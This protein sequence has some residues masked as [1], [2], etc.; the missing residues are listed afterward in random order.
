MFSLLVP[1]E[2]VFSKGDTDLGNFTAV[3]HHIDT[4]NA[5]PIK[6]RMRRTPLGYA[7]EERGHLEKL[8]EAGVIEPSCSEWASPSV[9]VRKRD[10]SVRWCIDLRKLNDVTVK[11]RYPLPLLQDCI[12]ALEGCQYF[13]TLD[14]ASG[15]YQL[16]VAQ[17][18]QDKTAFVTKYGLFSFRRMPFGLCNAPATFSRA[19]SLVLR[20]LSWRSVI[21]FLDDVVVL[22]QDFKSHLA[23]LSDVLGRFDK[24]GMKLKPKKCQLLQSSV[25]FLG[26]LVSRE[27]VQIPPG[28][29]ERVGNWGVPVC[30]KDVQSFIGVVN[31]HRDHIPLF[32]KIAKPLYDIMGSSVTFRWGTEQQEAFDDLKKKMTEAPVLAYPNSDDP[33]ILDTDASDHS[34]GAELLQVQDGIE[35]LIG[36]GSFVLDPAQR[37][38]CTTR[39]ELLA[40]VR[41]TRHFR[42]YLLGRRF[43]VRTDHSSLTWLMGFKNIEGQLA[44]WIEE[45]AVYNMDIIHRPGKDHVNADGFSRIP[46]PLRACR[47]YSAGCSVEDLPCGGCKYCVRANQQW[48]RFHEDVD[49]VVPLAVRCV[50]AVSD[51]GE[52]EGSLGGDLYPGGPGDAPDDY[53]GTSDDE[54][55]EVLWSTGKLRRLD[56]PEGISESTEEDYGW[57]DQ[58][59]PEDIRKMQMDDEAT[60]VLIGWLEEE[61]T[62][63]QAELALVSPATKYFWL[64]RQQLALVSGVLYFQRTSH[65]KSCAR[66]DD[67]WVLVAPESLQ[68][69]LFEHCHDHPSA[70]HMGMNKTLERMKRYA[71]WYKMQ[72]SCLVYVKSCAVCNRQKK[73]HRKPKAHQVC[74]HS[75]SPL[76]RIHI[77]ILGPLVETPRGNQ[78]VLVVVDQF[79]KWVECY[80]LPDQTAERVASTLV[81]E[82]IGRL[83]CPLELHSDQGRNFESHLFRNVCKM[84]QIAKTRTTP[85]RPSANGQVERMNRTILQILRCFIKDQQ[86]DWDLHLGT[87]GMAIRSTVNRQTGFTPN[88]LMLGRE[89]MQ[90]IDLMLRQELPDVDDRTPGSYAMRHKEAMGLAHRIARENLQQSQRRQKRDYDVRLEQRKYSV[91]DAVFRYNRSIVLGQSKKLQPIW[92]GPWVVE[93]VLSSV[94]YRIANRKRSMVAHH[95]SMKLCGD[96]DLPLWFRRK[97]HGLLGTEEEMPD[98]TEDPEKED[99]GLAGLFSEEPPVRT[100]GDDGVRGGD[101][102]VIPIDDDSESFG[103]PVEEE[104]GKPVEVMSRRGRPIKRPNYL[105]DYGS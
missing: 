92:T 102:E 4:G 39:K 76:E 18:D 51:H 37:K 105:D 68:N 55:D 5:K 28:E 38:Y 90:P 6:Q 61:A 45:L 97:R 3:Q 48:E 62:P 104:L 100:G 56:D 96:R 11:D 59:K 23:N 9:L 15:Y 19:V 16:E 41:F 78:Y 8:L 75:G 21:A 20:G 57:V 43:T 81:T 99:L 17:A 22:G 36:F 40:V 29:I 67:G 46:D 14:M 79:T 50:T 65:Q 66:R 101:D 84:L 64:L 44:R 54:D 72:E 71:I 103:D 82:F 70:G 91:G 26:R 94:L 2:K 1:R 53:E 32:A 47:C 12:D 98:V 73:P 83:G 60:A 87:V 74:Y 95:D 77:D 69:T 89:V 10:G 63:T 49:D 33:F 7:D 13:T 86:T 88:F 93:E 27:G 52:V 24:Y 31:F 25:V 35:R 85:Y 30:K 80:A 34:V 58:Y 42:H